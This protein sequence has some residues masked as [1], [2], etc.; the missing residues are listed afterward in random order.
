MAG[1]SAA[2]VHEPINQ[3]IQ[4]IRLISIIP[5]TTGPIR[6]NL[7]HVNLQSNPTPEYR[8]LSYVWGPPSPVQ[9]IQVNGHRFL[10][11]QNLYDFIYAFRERLYKFRGGNGYEDEVQWLW[12]DQIC[13]NQALIG[14]R[15]HQVKMMSDIYRRATYVYVWLGKS[16][17]NTEA[18]M[19]ALK[20]SYRRYHGPEP[21]TKRSKTSSKTSGDG[22]S[23]Q[24]EYVFST[25]A[26]RHFFDNPYWLRLWIVQEIMLARYIRVICGETLLSWDELKRFCSP[27]TL[28]NVYVDENVSLDDVVPLQVKWLTDHALSARHYSYA[29]LLATFSSSQCENPQDR[30]FGLQGLIPD[31]ERAEVDYGKPASQ[32]FAETAREIV[33]SAMSMPRAPFN[34]SLDHLDYSGAKEALF[35]DA[36]V[37]LMQKTEYDLHLHLVNVLMT[38]GDN[39]GMSCSERPDAKEMVL[40][41]EAIRAMWQKVAWHCERMSSEDFEFVCNMEHGARASPNPFGIDLIIEFFDLEQTMKSLYD[42]LLSIVKEFVSNMLYGAERP[43]Y[44]LY[45]F[46]RYRTVGMFVKR[47]SEVGLLRKSDESMD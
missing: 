45:T 19:K 15:N 3:A 33:R 37:I 13:I 26:L 10:V 22:T 7:T 16:D 36:T 9:E 47:L 17:D 34:R 43:A 25:P 38:L 11:R 46:K 32:I 35:S 39:M 27:S 8:A 41:L 21:L 28:S 24:A 2:F 12:I 4:E 23:M 30:V 20:S 6:C 42:N 40:A 14:E 31:A 18:V 44:T 1:S 29:Q 5:E